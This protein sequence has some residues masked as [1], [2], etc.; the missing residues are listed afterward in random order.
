MTPAR[1]WQQDRVDRAGT[2]WQ[3]RRDGNWPMEKHKSTRFPARWSAGCAI[4][5]HNGMQLHS[6]VRVDRSDSTSNSLHTTLDHWGITNSEANWLDTFYSNQ[7]CFFFIGL[8]NT[9]SL[10]SIEVSSSLLLICS[11]GKTGYA[12][13]APLSETS[14]GCHIPSGRVLLRLF[15][16][17]A[18]TVQP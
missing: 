6:V 3:S 17:Q 4:G 8:F 14:L 11:L 9:L 10:G 16:H 18:P 2:V 12:R 1:Q 5:E 13:C 7:L 15:A